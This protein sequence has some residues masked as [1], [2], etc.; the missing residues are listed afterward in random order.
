M[1][2][3]DLSMLGRRVSSMEE[4]LRS[5]TEGVLSRSGILAAARQAPPSQTSSSGGDG[6]DT[7][8]INLERDMSDVKVSLGKVETRLGHIE[9]NMVTKG[10]LAVY[11]VTALLGVLGG[12]WWIV[13]TYLSPIL[14]SLPKL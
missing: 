11:A 9:S 3:V 8:I 2:N 14:S 5:I 12:G 7:R 10:Q 4:N 1:E 13:Q 6:M